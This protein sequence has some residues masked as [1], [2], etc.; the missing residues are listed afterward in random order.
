MDLIFGKSCRRNPSLKKYSKRQTQINNTSL[1]FSGIF[2][3]FF[4]YFYFRKRISILENIF[5]RNRG[6]DYARSAKPL[7]Q[8]LFLVR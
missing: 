2:V 7:L 6:S 5:L 3:N 8:V 1:L 4:L